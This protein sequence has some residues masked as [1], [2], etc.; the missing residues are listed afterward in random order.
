MART[1]RTRRTDQASQ[2]QLSV[3]EREVLALVAGGLT[4]IF[5]RIGVTDGTQAAL[6]A[7]RNGL[8]R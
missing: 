8:R 2:Q 7:E 4:R 3:P 6:W 5:Q 1:L